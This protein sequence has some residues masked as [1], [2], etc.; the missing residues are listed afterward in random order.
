MFTIR[1]VITVQ[2]IGKLLL[3][4]SNFFFQTK[5]DTPTKKLFFHYLMDLQCVNCIENE[6]HVITQC[7]LYEDIRQSLFQ[8]ISSH[9]PGFMNLSDLDKTCF[10]LCDIRH[11]RTIAKALCDIL[12][13][14]RS[15]LLV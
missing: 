11:I 7:P 2:I 4:K 1:Y 13:R 14:R 12:E 9:V 3:Y 8:N 5:Y 15:I 6:C 10:L